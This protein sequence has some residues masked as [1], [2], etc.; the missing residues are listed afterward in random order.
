MTFT[1]SLKKKRSNS[2]KPKE[3]AESHQTLSSRAGSRN[4]T[5]LFLS[6]LTQ[7]LGRARNVATSLYF[8]LPT[9]RT[10]A[11]WVWTLEECQQ[12]WWGLSPSR[13]VKVAILNVL[14]AHTP[15]EQLM[16]QIFA[17]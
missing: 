12:D 5:S 10:E 16:V 9:E 13:A 15:S 11:A 17:T 6:S 2:L 8:S 4:K 14:S 3:L 7:K 1:S